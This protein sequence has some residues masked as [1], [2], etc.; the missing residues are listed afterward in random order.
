MS[1][2]NRSLSRS[3][4]FLLTSSMQLP[5][6]VRFKTTADRT[7]ISEVSEVESLRRSDRLRLDGKDCAG[8]EQQVKI[9]WSPSAKRESVM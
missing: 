7:R 3:C 1:D 8:H 4:I 6:D 5:K 9:A 2:Q